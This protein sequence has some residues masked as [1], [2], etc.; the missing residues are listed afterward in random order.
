MVFSLKKLIHSMAIFDKLSSVAPVNPANKMA[1]ANA[2][3]N[4]AEKN[5]KVWLLRNKQFKSFAELAKNIRM[6]FLAKTYNI[7]VLEKANLQKTLDGMQQCIKVKTRQGL[8]ERLESLSRQLG[9]KLSLMEDTG[10][11]ISSDMFF[12]EIILD[13]NTV[14]DVKVHHEG[15]VSRH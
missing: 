14:Q 12:L 7:D 4:L 3:N 10:L 1:L 15:N 11:F 9:L 6:H 8:I 13:K 2:K 5:N